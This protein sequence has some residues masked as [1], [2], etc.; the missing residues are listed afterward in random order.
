MSPENLRCCRL[1]LRH[2]VV[3]RFSDILEVIDEL[4]YTPTL[5]SDFYSNSFLHLMN[6]AGVDFSGRHQVPARMQYSADF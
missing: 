1:L 4:K 3:E 5:E 2:G 6:T